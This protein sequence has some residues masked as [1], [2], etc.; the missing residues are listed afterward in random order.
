MADTTT[1]NLSLTKPEVGASTDTWGTK[2]NT[3]LDTLDAVFKGDGTGTSVGLNVGAGKTLSVAG[4]L[5]V[6]GASSTIDATAIGSSTP[7]SGAFTTLSSTGNTTLGDASG[8]AVT[9]NGT[10]TFANANPVLTPGTASGVTYLNGSKVLTSGSALT[11]DGSTVNLTGS[12]TFR[13]TVTGG[14]SYTNLSNDGVY[15]FNSNLYLYAPS[16]KSLVFYSNDAEAMRLTGTSLYTASGINVGIGTSSPAGK[17]QVSSNNVE[18]YITDS[19][20]SAPD[21]A[22]LYLGIEGVTK[23]AGLISDFTNDRLLIRHNQAT[24]ATFDSAGNLGLGVTPSAWDT[25][26]GLKAFQFSA[27]GCVYNYSFGG[28]NFTAI[29]DNFYINS[30]GTSTYLTTNTASQYRQTAGA[31]Q[32]FQAASGTAGNPISFTQAMTLDTDGDLG[33]G[34]TSPGARIHAVSSASGAYGAII[35][36]NSAT[37]QGLTIRAGSTASHDAFNCQTYDGGIGLFSVQSGGNVI[38]PSGNLLVG[39]TS[40]ITSGK[41]T[42]SYDGAVNGL[43]ISESAN[44]A[45]TT[46]LGFNNGSSNIGAVTRVGST[47]AV[48]YGTTSDYRLKTVTGA[49][50]GQGSRIDALKPVDYQWKEGNTSA[51]GFLAHEFQTVYPNSVS[52]TKDAVDA[53]GNPKYQAMQASNSEVIAD[54]VAEIQ[55]LRQRLSAANL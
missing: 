17:L 41:Q 35:Y 12:G 8:D 13:S 28:N 11:F 21:S 23:Y 20:V 29:S 5:V 2:I 16:T 34:T 50:T 3:D 19:T 32:W 36:N 26:I 46:F 31:H 9:I 33:I 52:G 37:G 22:A 6:T 27:T 42:I 38:V 10:A 55:S 43:I 45:N 1:T 7:D 25:G 40:P 54:L 15:A 47:S 53:D 24:R 39:T 4:T 44:T 48:V 30:S 14:A 49:V 18:V 51:R